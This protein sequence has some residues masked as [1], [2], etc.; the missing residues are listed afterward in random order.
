MLLALL[1]TTLPT[2]E[3]K[4]LRSRFGLGF[5]QQIGAPLPIS[6]LSVRYGLPTGKPTSNI[7]LEADVGVAATASAPVDLYAGGRVLY[8]FVAEDNM[9]FYLAA[10]A[11]YAMQA[12][13]GLVRVQPAIGAEFFLFGLEN[14]GLSLEWGVSADLGEA[15]TVSTAPNAAVH[16]YF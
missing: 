9:N 16:Y 4:D 13:S 3:A 6:A 8:S 5:H 14:L 15:W 10:G 11:G 2:V 7:Q 1:V 12:G